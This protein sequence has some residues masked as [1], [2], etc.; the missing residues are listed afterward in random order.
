MNPMLLF[1]LGVTLCFLA[2]LVGCHSPSQSEHP[3]VPQAS[4]SHAD[5]SVPVD[6]APRNASTLLTT[7]KI[8]A[9]KAAKSIA[10][11]PRVAKFVA[12][13]INQDGQ[14]DIA[15]FGAGR[16]AKD[17]TKWFGRRDAD[18]DSFLTLTEFVPQS[19]TAAGGKQ[20]DEHHSETNI[21]PAKAPDQ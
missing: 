7:D 6:P 1:C 19:A 17:A 16:T 13:D 20:T 3:L 12:L 15:E 18:Q 2:G 10:D 14:L 9:K 4:T 21:L 8:P 5:A 11:N